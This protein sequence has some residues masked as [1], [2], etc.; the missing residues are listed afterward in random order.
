M[1]TVTQVKKISQQHRER[2]YGNARRN[3]TM[4][5]YYQRMIAD[6]V[7]KKRGS[8]D[9]IRIMKSQ[10]KRLQECNRFWV[11]ETYEASRVKILLKTYLCK[12][13]FCNNCNQVKKL[14]L[15][16]R[17]LPYMEKY[18]DSLYHIVLTVPDCSGAD[19]RATIQ[20]MTRCFKTL[21]NYL[22]GNKK[23]QGIDFL[24]YDFQGCIRSLEITY[25]EDSYHPHFHVAAVLGN[26]EVIGQKR[27]INQF[28]YSGNRLFSEFESIIQRVWWLLINRKRL[29]SANILE[30]SELLGRYSCSVDKFQSD[31]YKT[32]FEYMTKMYSAD[33]QFMSY[34][35]FKVLYGALNR[36]RQIQGYGVFYNLKNMETSNYT[37]QEYHALETHLL[38]NEEPISTYEP[39][40]RL[41]SSNGYTVLKTKPKFLV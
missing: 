15:Q 26:D 7:V 23:M 3:A 41:A 35:N 40:S 9:E 22:N 24:R 27:I 19:L 25:K 30:E 18:K 11:T 14:I 21:I 37:D 12:D 2:V 38:C 6:S 5:Y 32:L 20:H 10:L 16:N 17:F 29:T 28:S 4:I 36:I 34:E 33:N 8:P 1:E 31:D 39:L 13:K